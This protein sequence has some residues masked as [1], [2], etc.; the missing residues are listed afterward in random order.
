MAKRPEEQ[1]SQMIADLPGKTGK[2]LDEW[3]ELI[4]AES[5]TKHKEIRVF[6]ME[7]HGVGYGYANQIAL[8]AVH[9]DPAEPSEE[10]VAESLYSGPKAGLRP[11]HDALMESIHGFG[12][13]IDLAPKKGYVSLRRTKQFAMI[14]PSTATR[15][16]VGLILKGVE[17]EGRLEA[18]GGWNAMFSH[19]IRLAD[20]ADVDAEVIG[21][22][23][24]AYDAAY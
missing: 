9:G 10:D 12:D 5:L 1:L 21:W 11:I 23:R 15:V 19:R 4:R 17:P 2:P 18:S 14:Q 6:L 20:V 16:D 8:R 24:K 13:D 7:K 22:I 3:L